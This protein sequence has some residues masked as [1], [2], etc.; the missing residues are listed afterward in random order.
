MRALRESTFLLLGLDNDLFSHFNEALEPDVPNV[1]NTIAP[2]HR[3]STDEALVQA[4]ALRDLF[5]DL[6][7]ACGNVGCP[8]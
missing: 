7:S 5:M 3:V 6:F 8:A 1:V 2:L 4:A